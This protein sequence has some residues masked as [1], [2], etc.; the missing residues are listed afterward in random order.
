MII[1][2]IEIQEP[3]INANRENITSVVFFQNLHLPLPRWPSQQ[4]IVSTTAGI[5][6][7]S[8]EK[9]IEPTKEMNGSSSGT[10][11]ATQ[12][13][14]IRGEFFQNVQQKIPIVQILITKKKIKDQRSEIVNE[15]V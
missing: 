11:N 5:V 15:C 12:T 9:N 10:S 6:M 3:N 14:I 13:E 2:E 7:P 4:E 8:I 1:S